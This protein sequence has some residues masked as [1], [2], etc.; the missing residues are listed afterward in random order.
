MVIQL[1]KLLRSK[2]IS[3]RTLLFLSLI[4]A[5]FLVT[6]VKLIGE[7]PS[8]VYW[9]EASIGY[10]AFSISSDLRDEWG[11]LLPLH[12]R[13]F[14]EFKLPVYIYT[15]SIFVKLLGLGAT[16]VRLPAVLFSLGS[17]L[18]IFLITLKLTK[19]SVAGLLSAFYL[20]FSPWFFIFSRTGY[21]ATA[22]VFFLLL[23]FLLF[24]NA[25]K[26]KRY[27]FISVLSY[28]LAIYSYNSMRVIIPMLFVVQL[29]Y[30]YLN[31]YS[32]KL[33]FLS[34]LL[35]FIFYLPILRLYFLDSGAV[36]FTTVAE[37]GVAKIVKNYTSHFGAEFLLEGDKNLRS[38]LPGFGVVW[39]LDILFVLMGTFA[40]FKSKRYLLILVLFGFLVSFIPAALA[41]EAPHALRS[42]SAVAFLSIIWA[43]GITYLGRLFKGHKWIL[44][45]SVVI[46]ILISF[47][48]YLGHFLSNYNT[49]A[50]EQWQYSYKKVYQDYENMYKDSKKIVVSDFYGQPYIFFLF[51][52]KY[53][54]E[55][56]REEVVYNPP[57]KW[58]AS[59]VAKFGSFE[60]KKIGD[61]DFEKGNIIFASESE[62]VGMR[63]TSQI[64]FL[65]NSFAFY[66]YDER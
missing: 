42:L 47:E 43:I 64:K 8:S 23:G 4:I 31:K 61:T 12:F 2:G 40:I 25:K 6:R 39:P 5:I 29:V 59:L 51:Y 19:N 45:T 56:F 63:E 37:V 9:D 58:G 21:E 48:G 55:N 53:A 50:S 33:L 10:N 28:A 32:P 30:L 66:V 44:Y 35:L 18:T 15:T 65:D 22:G 60:F 11:E 46:V 27:L 3:P 52:S 49:L 7:I 26:D 57:D 1:L 34:L 62:R 41:K 16:A 38:T 54:P 17:V 13:A 14:G 24:L 36:R 20:T